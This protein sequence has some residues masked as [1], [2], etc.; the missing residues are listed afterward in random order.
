MSFISNSGSSGESRMVA[1]S[2]FN[3]IPIAAF[4]QPQLV[5]S[6]IAPPPV[7]NSSPLSLA[8]KPKMEGIG[9]MGMIGENFDTGAMT[10]GAREEDS[11]SKFGSD[12]MEGPSGNDHDGPEAKSSKMKKYHRHTP[13]QIQELEA[14]FKDNPHPDEKA[15]LELGRRLN[16]ENKQVKFW[17]QNRRTQMKTQLERYENAILKQENDKL[18]IENIAIKDAIRESTLSQLCG[19]NY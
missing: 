2:A 7:F 13:Y 8:L 3:S 9:E 16:L 19:Y 10:R 4:A 18:R 17:F 11:D 6:P 5:P 14:S 15:R 1:C 12:N